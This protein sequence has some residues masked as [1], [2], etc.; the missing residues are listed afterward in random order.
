VP[1]PYWAV[2]QVGRL[3]RRAPGTRITAVELP[4]C[5]AQWIDARTTFDGQRVI[6]YFPGGGFFVGGWH[7]HRAFLSRLSRRTNSLILAVDY[8]KLP[9]NPF[10]RAAEDALDAYRELLD[11][12]VAP[13]DIVIG[14]DSA[15]GF[16][17]L[18]LAARLRE[19]DLPMPAAVVAISPLLSLVDLSEGGRGCA[20]LTP[21][22]I[23]VLARYGN[24]DGAVDAGPL[25]LVHS[26]L[27]PV[28]IQAAAKETLCGQ[29]RAYEKLLA[30]HGVAHDV[31]LW[32]VDV[33]V[34]H[35]AYWL[36]EASEALNEIASFLDRV[37]M[38]AAKT[39][40]A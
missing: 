32:P 21:R 27:P 34:F 12:G 11:E 9:H 40:A 2:D 14:G 8:R 26:E 6:L 15:G 3:S 20:V 18:Q 39:A 1:W 22:A 30:E 16:L 28:L 25:A 36:P 38:A 24:V 4:H 29:V 19:Q 33:H 13:E 37:P 17:A 10:G 31:Q 35:A 5:R 23:S 7:L